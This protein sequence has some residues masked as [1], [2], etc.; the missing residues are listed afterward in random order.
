MLLYVLVFISSASL[1]RVPSACLLV[2]VCVLR[3]YGW[4]VF[5]SHVRGVVDSMDWQFICVRRVDNTY[6]K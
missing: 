6:V 3:L 5:L 1:M 2:S 4:A